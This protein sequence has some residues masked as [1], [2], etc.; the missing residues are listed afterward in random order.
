MYMLHPA[1]GVND[2]YHYY[3]RQEAKRSGVGGGLH[4][5]N[6]YD[7]GGEPWTFL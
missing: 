1:V 7:M 5:D 3:C 4:W 2:W 6:T